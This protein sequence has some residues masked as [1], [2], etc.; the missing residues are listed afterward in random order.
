MAVHAAVRAEPPDVQLFALL[1]GVSD[2][3]EQR[4]VFE[5]FAVLDLFGD[6]SQFLIDDAAGAHVQVPDL[7]IAHLP[8]RQADAHAA[9]AQL[10]GGILRPVAVDVG[11]AL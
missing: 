8:F 5:K 7:G 9:G 4:L 3:A 2:G 10:R 6:L 11:A 1:F